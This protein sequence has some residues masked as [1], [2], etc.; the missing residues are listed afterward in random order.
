MLLCL[1]K[2]CSV[3]AQF[4]RLTSVLPPSLSQLEKV[5]SASLEPQYT[6]DVRQSHVRPLY[7]RGLFSHCSEQLSFT[8][9]SDLSNCFSI[10]CWFPHGINLNVSLK[11]VLHFPSSC[12]RVQLLIYS[13]PVRYAPARLG[14][15]SN[16][17]GTRSRT[18]AI[19]STAS[20]NDRCDVVRARSEGRGFPIQRFLSVS[21]IACLSAEAILVEPW[22][23]SPELVS[24]Q[25]FCEIFI[26]LN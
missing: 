20:D 22:K 26:N 6:V 3:K 5:I 24:F 16:F 8:M 15:G 23:P 9:T 13:L 21:M 19:H 2:S 11:N 17:H 14:F 4:S 12:T 7:R 18:W 10:F 25:W 1:A